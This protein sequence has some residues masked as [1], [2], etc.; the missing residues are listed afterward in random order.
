MKNL[1][2]LI[3]VIAVFMYLKMQELFCIAIPIIS[4][5]IWKEW[6]VGAIIPLGGVFSAYYLAGAVTFLALFYIHEPA[7]LF[8]IRPKYDYSVHFVI[9]QLASLWIIGLIVGAGIYYGIKDGIIG[10]VWPK[11]VE[12]VKDNWSRATTQ[13]A[14]W[15]KV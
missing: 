5:Y 13:V 11:T 10:V 15:E 3:K 4:K 6:V 9:M 8:F 14:E 7:A 2:T 12:L 1:L